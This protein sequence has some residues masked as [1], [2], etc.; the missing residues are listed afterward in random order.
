MKVTG[1]WIEAAHVQQ[2]LALL[3]EGGHQALLVGGCVRNALLGQAVSDIDISTDATPER[4]MALAG[5]AGLR[6]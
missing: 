3:E 5:A 2:V 4:V 6:A 1:A